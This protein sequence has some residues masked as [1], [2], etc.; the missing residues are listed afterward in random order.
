M[1][2]IHRTIQ[3]ALIP[4]LAAFLVAPCSTKK[5]PAKMTT[6]QNPDAAPQHVR[7]LLESGKYHEAT[8]AAGCFWGVQAAFANVPGVKAT[9][10][11]YTGGHTPNPTYRQVCSHK[12]GHA[13]AVRIIYDPNYISYDMLLHLFWSIHD[14]TTLNRQGPDVGSQ[15]RSAVFYHTPEQLDAARRSKERL[16]QSDRF[17][18]PVVTE[19]TLASHFYKA[20]EYHQNYFQKRGIAS[21]HAATLS[22]DT[23]PKI[24][25]T[26]QQ[27]KQLLTPTQYRITRRKGTERAFTGKYHDFKEPG[28]YKCLCC[29]NE[30]FSSQTKFDSGTGWPS[31][32]APIAEKNVHKKPDNTLLMKR[33]EVLCSRCD[34]HLG[35]V[36]NDGPAPTNLRYCINSAALDFQ[37]HDK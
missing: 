13:E 6:E 29:G 16:Q 7:E 11:G 37:P 14:P 27:W 18:A 8:F 9:T 33:T 15:Y 25:K 28:L 10:V 31:F 1:N 19:I 23:P 17:P 35:H 32:Y 2:S 3:V 21:C 34:A 22:P 12:T 20:E 30:L 5:E 36:F 26:D 24:T 4:A